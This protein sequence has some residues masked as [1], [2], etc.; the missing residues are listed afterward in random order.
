[1]DSYKLFRWDRQGKKGGGVAL[2]VMEHFDC[3]ELND[4]DYRIRCLLARIRGKAN[5]ADIPLGV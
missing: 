3:T 5:K 1:M 4:C 2:Y